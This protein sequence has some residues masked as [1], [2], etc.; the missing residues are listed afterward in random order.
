MAADPTEKKKAPK[1]GY[2]PPKGRPTRHRNEVARTRR[3]S[4]TVE[5]I[6]VTI[7]IVVLLGLLFWFGRD[8]RSTAAALAAVTGAAGA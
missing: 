1:H 3:L 2:T 6:L 7:A 4:S 5:W 8:F